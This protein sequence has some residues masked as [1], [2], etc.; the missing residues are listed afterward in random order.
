MT[1]RAYKIPIS[2]LVVVVNSRQEVLLIRRVLDSLT[3]QAL[4]KTQT[5]H[6]QTQAILNQAQRNHSRQFEFWQSITGSLD[7][8]TETIFQAVC[9]EVLEEISVNA[10]IH[11][12]TIQSFKNI[13][14]KDPKI[15]CHQMFLCDLQKSSRYEIA[16]IWRHRY[17]AD[18]EY[19]HEH[20]FLLSVP[21][22]TAIKLNPKE[23]DQ[24][25]WVPWRDAINLCFSPSNQQMLRYIFEEFFGEGM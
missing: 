5:D 14:K 15:F 7:D 9:R 20:A 8:A 13:V 23:H 1:D 3:Q 24:A 17:A 12:N 21:A 11:F 18:V 2:A 22:G 6:P 4:K 16:K 10:P 19:N 25:L